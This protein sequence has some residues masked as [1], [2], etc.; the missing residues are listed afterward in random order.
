MGRRCT[1]CISPEKDEINRKLIEG[2]SL[3]KIALQFKITVQSL[4]RH[5]QGH[6][7]KELAEAKE[8]EEVI[9]ADNLLDRLRDLQDRALKILNTCE[10]AGTLHVALDAIARSAQLIELQAKLVGMLKEKEVNIY[11]MPE[12]INLQTIILKELEDYPDLRLRI[13]EALS[14]AS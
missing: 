13:S 6:L 10:E 12:F 1:V 9:K 4:W 8:A 11:V 3:R 14:N 7:P 2:A 5:K